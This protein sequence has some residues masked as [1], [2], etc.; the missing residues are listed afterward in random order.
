MNAQ[1]Q[2]KPI[3]PR[4]ADDGAHACAAPLQ[5]AAAPAQPEPAAREREAAARFLR[6]FRVLLNS[7][8]LYQKNHPHLMESLEAA[9]RDLRGALQSSAP[10]HLAV[11]RSG[12]RLRA[13]APQVADPRG[14]LK[15]L[16]EQ[17]GRC[18][19]TSLA[20]SAATNLGELD[21]LA[22]LLNR[23][24][25][26]D[27]AALHPNSSGVL[28]ADWT[29][30]LAERGVSGIR[31]NAPAE[32][33]SDAALAGWMTAMRAY[34]TPAGDGSAPQATACASQTELVAT[35]R[36]LARMATTLE[37]TRHCAPQEAANLFQQ[38]LEE[39][40]R[41]CVALLAELLR[42]QGPHGAERYGAYLARLADSLMRQFVFAEFEAG[43]VVAAG[44]HSYFARLVRELRE[45]PRAA[46]LALADEDAHTERLHEEFWM[47][48]PTDRIARALRGRDAWCVPPAVVRAYLAHV[49][50]A[51]GDSGVDPSRRARQALL[52]Y[53]RCLRAEE[54]RARRS[55]TAGLVELL[56]LAE[57]LWPED[58]PQ[59]L[60]RLCVRALLREESPGIAALLTAITE[61]LARLALA[62]ADYSAFEN[63]LEPLE[64]APRDAGHAHLNA[65]ARRF[66][67]DE[68][69][70]HLVDAAV[71]A[72]PRKG[73]TLGSPL[74]PALPRLL[75]R[76]PERL[77]DRLGLILTAPNGLDT[78]AAMGRLLRAIGEPVLGTL[79][80]RLFDPRHQRAAAAVKLLAIT[81]P[82][83]LLCVL[84]RVL[85]GWDWSLQD[86]AVTELARRAATL[87]AAGVARTLA[88][89]VA[90]AHPLV[91]P[92]ILDHIGLAE[93]LSAVP[94]LLEIAAGRHKNLREVYI[95]IKAVEALGR[96][97]V[98]EAA[99]LLR[100]ILR[101]RIGLTHTEPAGLR[102]AAEEALSMI[103]NRPSSARVRATQQALEK[104]SL[105]FVRARRYLRIPLPA[106]LS[107]TMVGVQSG[108]ARIRT[109]SLGGA[110][111]ECRSPLHVGDSIRLSFRAG[112]RRIEST[113]VVR[114]LAPNGGGVEFVHLG[115]DDREHL[116][117]FV[118]RQL[119]N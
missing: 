3:R 19:V 17:L 87:P 92:V 41:R 95:R 100:G 21:A 111:V 78:L 119:H 97:H 72:W 54:P 53:A 15:P 103:E 2:V 109:V 93:E 30:H 81:Q 49:L 60:A 44:V 82:E 6:S 70:L 12:F 117:R 37:A 104:S 76:D 68:R 108:P 91:V 29:A 10:L 65:L 52:L 9:E 66:I 45:A 105:P 84:P 25:Q 31:I 64:Q 106:P 11:D 112:L 102:A 83:R 67:E 62:R 33:Q 63:L 51:K 73:R 79:E 118:S 88:G 75:G 98:S 74:D 57:R 1:A 24:P 55:V 99:D 110:F 113:A 40:D 80:N 69:W 36:L 4:P 46:S 115:A 56:P 39:S 38:A 94:L 13:G 5:V 14:E 96:M 7:T 89:I 43:R 22:R 27:G 48:L 47:G 101:E 20:F 34:A 18:G 71:F 35:L 77:L 114:N 26:N 107:A 58:S 23:A 59:D 8:R 28:A 16:A 61:N 42:R 85:A 32:R 50:A 90:E 116:R 86:L